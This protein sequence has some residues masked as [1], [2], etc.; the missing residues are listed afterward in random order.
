MNRLMRAWIAAIALLG[1]APAV[2]AAEPSSRFVRA[3]RLRLSLDR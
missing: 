2:A 1:L 3:M